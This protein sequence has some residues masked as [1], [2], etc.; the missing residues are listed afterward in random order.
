[1]EML[2]KFKI[3][4]LV[5]VVGCMILPNVSQAAYQSR[6]GFTALYNTSASDFFVNIRKMETSSGPMGLSMSE[7]YIYSGGDGN[8]ID[9]HM[10]K[11]SEWGAV[12]MLALSGYGGGTQSNIGT[13]TTG[14]SNYTGVYGMGNS[15]YEYTATF[16]TSDGTTVDTSNSYVKTLQTAAGGSGVSSRYYDL[17]YNKN[18]EATNQDSFYEY[19][20]K[21]YGGSNILDHHGDAIY[22]IIGM[23]TGTHNTTTSGN[24]WFRR[25]GSNGGGVLASSNIDGNAGSSYTSRA[26]VVCGSGL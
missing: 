5:M 16:A 12:A 1:M 23:F 24:P 10:I 2:K 17:Y 6:P 9:V 14:S 21:K 26:V 7:N 3:L 13:Y 11:N 18:L 8:G 20:Y 25:G 22:E 19:N 15:N 4:I